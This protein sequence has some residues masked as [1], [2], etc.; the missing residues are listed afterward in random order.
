MDDTG[1]RV[2][3]DVAQAAPVRPPVLKLTIKER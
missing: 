1:Y 3:F 2:V